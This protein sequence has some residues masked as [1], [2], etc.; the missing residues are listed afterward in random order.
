VLFVLLVAIASA[1]T[2]GDAG[3]WAFLFTY[4]AACAGLIST[5]F[6][7][8]GVVACSVL[9]G[10]T[11]AIW[12]ASGGQ[13]IGYV[14]SSAGIGFL[15]L[16]MRDLRIRNEQLSE[17]RAELARLAVA[18][19]RERFAR[20]LHDLLGHSLSLIA[21]KS[22]LARRLLPDRPEDAARELTDVEA[23]ARQAL[24]EV[25]EAVSGYRRPTMDGELEGARVALAAAGIQLTV[26]QAEAQLEPDVE[27]VLAWTVREGVTNVI[28]HS[29]ARSCT[30]RVTASDTGRGVEVTDDGVGAAAMNGRAGSGVAGLE[31]R[32]REVGGV[33]EAGPRP[34]GGFRLAVMVP[35]RSLP[36]AATSIPPQSVPARR[37]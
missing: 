8:A 15:L 32:A 20:D 9:A 19:E 23:V 12:G 6:G 29:H 26:D 4:C 18:E 2:L 11:S 37:R 28:R 1:L 7:F 10:V 21:L 13:V 31:Q 5:R 30:V 35:A 22:E 33:V 36:P 16:V 34:D 3:G 25:R 27:A 14:A 17:A 24:T